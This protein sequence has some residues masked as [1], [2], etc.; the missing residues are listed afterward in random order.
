MTE[1][2]H[3]GMHR[4]FTD[5]G[6]VL[7]FGGG[8]KKGYLYGKTAD[9]RPCKTI[10]NRVVIEDLHATIYRA[11]G[12]SPKLAYEVEKRPFYVTRDGKGKPID[13]A[14]LA[15]GLVVRPRP[16]RRLKEKPAM[17][18]PA[19]L[20]RRNFLAATA[21]ASA[22]CLAGVSARAAGPATQ[23]DAVLGQGDYRYKVVPGWGVLDPKK[24]PVNDCHSMVQDA[25]GRILLLTNDTHNN[26]IIY[27]KAG[28][29]LDTWGH[30]FPGVHG[31]TLVNE[32][33]EE[34]LFITDYAK[35]QVY[36]TTIDGKV[37]MTLGVPV[38]SG[39]F[40]PKTAYKPTDIVVRPDG[41]FYVLD[42]YGTSFV[43]RYGPKGDLKSVFGGKGKQPENLNEAHGG[44][45]DFRSQ[46][47]PLLLIT[48]RQDHTIK[49]FTLDG[50]YVDDLPFPNMLPCNIYFKGDVAYVPHLRM[51][52]G[53]SHGFLTV[54]GR[55]DRILSNPGGA[56]AEY[57]ADGKL[58]PLH[59]EQNVFI[60]PHGLCVDDEDSLYVAQWASGK[61]YPIKLQRV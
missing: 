28:R 56:P 50:A 32:N 49:R 43:F 39:K 8:I 41:D 15:H 54:L 35:G 10:E 46:D 59:R 26:V 9:E 48:S 33:G 13:C 12:I 20:S 7:L 11:L 4:H 31:M 40:P 2:K 44:R 29:M 58:K 23:P 53:N 60:H 47:K 22:A 1:L 42:G 5:A 25:K 34:F 57:D 52:D 21:A 6:C 55:D 45:I 27:D 14:V 19:A 30:A 24:N 16:S 51:V 18:H 36:K 38:E 37:L 17:H 3:Y 61:T